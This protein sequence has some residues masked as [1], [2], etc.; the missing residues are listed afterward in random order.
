MCTKAEY[1]ASMQQQLNEFDAAI[2]EYEKKAQLA[3]G[4]A[5]TICTESLFKLRQQQMLMR[6]KLALEAA[7]EEESW[8]QFRLESDRLRDAI[9]QAC[10]TFKMKL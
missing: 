3:C 7:S 9:L 5:K 8:D 6:D 2:G 1:I 4:E 10:N